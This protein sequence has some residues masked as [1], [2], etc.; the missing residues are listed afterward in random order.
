MQFFALLRVVENNP[1]LENLQIAEYSITH[2]VEQIIYLFFR[3]RRNVRT[4][5]GVP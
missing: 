1:Y 3:T 4:V 2:V 5:W